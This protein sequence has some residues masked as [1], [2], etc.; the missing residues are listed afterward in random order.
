[1]RVHFT[2]QIVSFRQYSLN[3]PNRAFVLSFIEDRAP[4]EIPVYCSSSKFGGV[5][6][7]ADA[8]VPL[9]RNV[10]E[11]HGVSIVQ[12]RGQEASPSLSTPEGSRI[13]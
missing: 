8:E 13:S 3:Q 11:K 10:Q 5:F 9:E 12:K 4:L 2:T 7:W 1:M 6:P